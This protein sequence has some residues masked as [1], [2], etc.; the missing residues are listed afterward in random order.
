[1]R[2][3]E[4]QFFRLVEPYVHHTNIPSDFIYCFSYAVEPE[5]SQPTGGANHSRI[6]DVT[7]EV[8]VDPRMF[9]DTG[10]SP[11][12]ILLAAR[13]YNLL[14]FKHGLITKKF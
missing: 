7:I 6:D 4:A 8:N 12:N 10:G 2:E 5:D 3:R 1:M 11:I 9:N 14:R 13:S